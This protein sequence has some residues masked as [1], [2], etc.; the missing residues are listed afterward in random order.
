MKGYMDFFNH[1]PLFKPELNLL[2]LKKLTLLHI[3]RSHRAPTSTVSFPFPF[4]KPLTLS[5]CCV[6]R[7]KWRQ[8]AYKGTP[9]HHE[10]QPS[11][12]RNAER[13]SANVLQPVRNWH[14]FLV[15]TIS[16]WSCSVSV[17]LCTTFAASIFTSWLRCDRPKHPK[18]Q[19]KSLVWW[20]TER[21]V[22]HPYLI[23]VSSFAP[24][25]RQCHWLKLLAGREDSE[26]C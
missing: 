10:W 1:H 11:N 8:P 26:F 22:C 12:Q 20:K 2:K 5:C 23:S 19:K 9:S 17:N 21:F 7:A 13:E 18:G 14:V 6:C 16:S 25:F 4:T 3:Y 15:N 24:K